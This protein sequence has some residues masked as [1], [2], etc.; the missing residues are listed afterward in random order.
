MSLSASCKEDQGFR[1]FENAFVA[2]QHFVV[3]GDTRARGW[4]QTGDVVGKVVSITAVLSLMS[5]SLPLFPEKD[6]SQMFLLYLYTT[7]SHDFRRF[8]LLKEVS[9]RV[10][11]FR[12]FDLDLKSHSECIPDKVRYSDNSGSKRQRHYWLRLHCIGASGHRSRPH[13]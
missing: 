4:Y 2:Q 7:K 13:P 9:R 1:V 10:S 8:H 6:F 5:A 11:C 12:A 3:I